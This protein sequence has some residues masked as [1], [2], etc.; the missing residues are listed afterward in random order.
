MNVLVKDINVLL[1]LRIH[2]NYYIVCLV[3]SFLHTTSP[4]KYNTQWVLIM[5]D[6]NKLF[7][8]SGLKMKQL[9]V[10]IV[11]WSVTLA[12]AVIKP[13]PALGGRLVAPSP[14]PGLAP[15]YLNIR[16]W[17]DNQ[18]LYS[19]HDILKLFIKFGGIE[20]FCHPAM[21][22]KPKKSNFTHE[23]TRIFVWIFE[24]SQVI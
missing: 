19:K 9:K 10:C 6:F 12:R 5:P 3:I 16:P 24:R 11:S 7:S 15:H 18:T 23:D 21:T 22:L 14:S 8:Q 1:M 20:N 4:G 13:G 2:T 17:L